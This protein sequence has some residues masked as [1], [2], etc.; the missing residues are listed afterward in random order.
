ML[1]KVAHKDCKVLVVA[2]PTNTNCLVL[3]QAAPSLPSTN[4]T[5]LTRLDLNR[6]K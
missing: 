3:Q 6:T 4:F 5:C 2:N 1:D